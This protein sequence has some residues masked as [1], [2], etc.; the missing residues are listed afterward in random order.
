MHVVSGNS[1]QRRPQ[2]KSVRPWQAKI[3]APQPA[4]PAW[5]GQKCHQPLSASGGVGKT[6]DSIVMLILLSPDREQR[7]AA[8]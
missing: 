7:L 4:M 1:V 8:A 2:P 3:I 5:A 6:V